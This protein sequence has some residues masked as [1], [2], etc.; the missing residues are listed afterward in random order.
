MTTAEFVTYSKDIATIVGVL[1]AAGAL[2]FTARN[3]RS[4]A[5]ATRA[6]FWLDLREMF[7]RFDD[8]HRKLRP[9]GQWHGAGGPKTVDEWAEV[10]SYMGLFEHCEAMLEQHLIDEALFRDIYEYRLRNIEA[11]DIIRIGK[12]IQNA[13]GWKRFH[14]LLTRMGIK[15]RGLKA[16]PAASVT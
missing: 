16:A 15:V 11:N 7:Y 1:I 13:Q 12:L 10:E 8:V 5:R 4:T 2:V 3:S 6:K 14:A 9:G